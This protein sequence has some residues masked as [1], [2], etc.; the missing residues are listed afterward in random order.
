MRFGAFGGRGV[1]RVRS[2]LSTCGRAPSLFFAWSACLLVGIF[3]H[4][5]ASLHSR[6][7]GG[8]RL[9]PGLMR[10]TPQLSFQTLGEVRPGVGGGVPAGGR[11]GGC[12]SRGSGGGVFLP[13]VGG[14]VLAGG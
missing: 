11:G 3:H 5:Y 10:P 1:F 9:Q 8:G 12:S 2:A 4:C 7:G 6:G 14:G 13:E